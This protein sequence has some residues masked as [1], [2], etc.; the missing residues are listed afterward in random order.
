MDFHIQYSCC[1]IPNWDFNPKYF[2]EKSHF[3]FSSFFLFV[4]FFLE[5]GYMKWVRWISFYMN[6]YDWTES[7]CLSERVFC[8]FKIGT[9]S[10]RLSIFFSFFFIESI[11][12]TYHLWRSSN[13]IL[14]KFLTCNIYHQNYIGSL[15]IWKNWG[16]LVILQANI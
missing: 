13:M 9:V 12:P 16:P 2:G 4:F 10:I 6:Y 5:K 7:G 3:I 8:P 11:H 15:L 1:R 14:S